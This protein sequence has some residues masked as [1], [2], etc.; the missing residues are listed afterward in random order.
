M[1]TALQFGIFVAPYA[2]QIAEMEV[3]II[4]PSV[5]VTSITLD[6]ESEWVSLNAS[7]ICLGGACFES[8]PARRLF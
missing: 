8:Q 2:I 6:V 4:R 7:D 1:L 5:F 3:R